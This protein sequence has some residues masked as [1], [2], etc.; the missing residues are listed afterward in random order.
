M[1]DA[2]RRVVV[3]VSLLTRSSLVVVVVIRWC[4]CLKR[5]GKWEIGGQHEDL[6]VRDD[7]HIATVG[8]ALHNGNKMMLLATTEL[9][10]WSPQL[11]V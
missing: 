9:S 6:I 11:V 4:K 5:L 1:R 3:S 2:L 8:Q 10:S 7:E